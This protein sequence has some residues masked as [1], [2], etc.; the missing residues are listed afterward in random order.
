MGAAEGLAAPPLLVIAGAGSGK[1][2]TLAPRVAH[3]IVRGAEP[4]LLAEIEYRA[5]SAESKSVFQ[6][7]K[8]GL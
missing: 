1:I 3:L 6:G 2:N 4:E 8:E 7:I 5:E